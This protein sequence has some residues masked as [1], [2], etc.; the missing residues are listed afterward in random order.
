MAV[1]RASAAVSRHGGDL[2]QF[3]LREDQVVARLVRRFG[4]DRGVLRARIR[5][6]SQGAGR[7]DE[8]QPEEGG[9]GPRRREAL[10]PWD[11]EVLEILV[12]VPEGAGLVVRE[13]PADDLGSQ[14]GRTV[15]EAARQ[16]FDESGRVELA[17]LFDL[18]P[19]PEI[20]SLL[21]DVDESAA[22]RRGLA[23]AERIQHLEE[24]LRLRQVRR[25]TERT[26]RIL[27]TQ[28]LDAD[29]EAALLEQIVA[30]R[31]LA[32]GMSDPKEG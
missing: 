32:Q 14:F 4:L 26:S 22:A 29:A 21:V 2:S 31:R 20:Q 23:A 15:L 28:S 24:T 3:R 13:V 16:L 7:R 25:E 6:L 10:P 5:D 30:Q 1:A 12:S 18:L 8:D 17:G 11:Q 27:K 19:D 9:R